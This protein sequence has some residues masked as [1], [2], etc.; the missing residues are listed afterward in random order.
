MNDEP[1][2]PPSGPAFWVAAT[3]GVALISIGVAGM[4]TTQESDRL[5]NWGLWLG[6]AIVIHDLVL[7]PVAIIA[8]CLLARRA[9]PRS[10]PPIA[11]ALI[12]A[13][14]LAVATAPVWL[15]RG[16]SRYPDNHTIL[17]DH[18]YPANLALVLGAIAAVTLTVIA[19]R[20]V[21]R[22]RA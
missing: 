9:R 19:T 3:A 20:A 18:S 21:R 2:P 16:R 1:H 10:G 5:V 8:G 13:A 14:T 15:Q 12:V 6:G 11:G 7:A 22:R 4:F 17:P